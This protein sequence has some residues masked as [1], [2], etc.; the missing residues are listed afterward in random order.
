M[1]NGGDE[2]LI[3]KRNKNET[4]GATFNDYPSIRIDNKGRS[5]PFEMLVLLGSAALPLCSVR[6]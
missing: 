5:Q 1:G 3:T 2:N 6:G 4:I